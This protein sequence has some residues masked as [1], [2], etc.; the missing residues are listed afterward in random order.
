M[1]EGPEVGLPALTPTFS[2]PG[3]QVRFGAFHRCISSEPD[4]FGG[5]AGDDGSVFMKAHVAPTWT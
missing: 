2:C 5:V 3:P 1:R 4:A